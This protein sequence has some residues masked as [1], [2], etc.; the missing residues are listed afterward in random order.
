[1]APAKTFG[2]QL[3][4]VKWPDP[5]RIK[6]VCRRVHIP[7]MSFLN[8][9]AFLTSFVLTFSGLYFISQYVNSRL[10]DAGYD[11]SELILIGLPKS[12]TTVS[13]R[14][15]TMGEFDGTSMDL[16]NSFH[17]KGYTQVL[18]LVIAA[19]SS[20]FIFAK[21]G[22]GSKYGAFCYQF[23]LCGSLAERKPALNPSL[24]QEFRLAKKVVISPNTALSVL[25]CFWGFSC[26]LT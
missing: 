12:N 4:R 3:G 14:N 2:T 23:Y 1:M 6:N 11:I 25:P 9:F 22:Y 16:L 17:E 5:Q 8:Q 15:S 19:V 26:L 24:W 13:N 21:F 20:V 10:L 7:R 18:A